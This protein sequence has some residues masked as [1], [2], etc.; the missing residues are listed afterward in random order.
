MTSFGMAANLVCT[1][2]IQKAFDEEV[3]SSSRGS[4]AINA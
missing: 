3:D 1:S 4:S 2:M